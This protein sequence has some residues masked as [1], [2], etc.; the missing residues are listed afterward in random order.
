MSRSRSRSRSRSA[1][2]PPQSLSL[3]ARNVDHFSRNGTPPK[4]RPMPNSEPE[5]FSYDV[6]SYL[7]L[8]T[9]A[10]L[11]EESRILEEEAAQRRRELIMSRSRSATP[12]KRAGVMTTRPGEPGELSLS[13]PNPNPN[14]YRYVKVLC[15][16]PLQEKDTGLRL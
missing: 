12:T 2:P 9:E 6:P 10:E 5:P 11:E 14:L 13:G 15:S 7:S 1:T 8:P 4:Y 3:T 16:L